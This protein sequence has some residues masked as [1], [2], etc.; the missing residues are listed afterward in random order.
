M[1]QFMALNHAFST[2]TS[3]NAGTV[4]NSGTDRMAIQL[5]VPS[6]RRIRIIEYGVSFNDTAAHTPA[7]VELVEASTA[8]TCSTAHTTSTVKAIGEDSGAT[9][10]LTFGATTN[11]GYGNGAITSTT[12]SRYF[13]SQ[14]VPPTGQ[15]VK[16]WPLGREPWSVGSGIYVQLRIQTSSNANAVAYIVWEEY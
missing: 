9:S 1:A 3:I 15:F 7:R 2:T 10:A 12:T 4:Y 5:Q 11:T 13:D 14:F 8:S 16:Q 6:G